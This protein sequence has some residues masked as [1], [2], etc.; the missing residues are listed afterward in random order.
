MHL[1]MK[2]SLFES[3]LGKEVKKPMDL[4]ISMGCK[5]H[6]KEVVDMVKGREAKYARAKKLLEHAQKGYEK[7][8]NKTQRHVEFEVGQHVWL[9]I[10]DFKMRNGLAPC[11]I[12][13]YARFHEIL[14]KLHPNVY[15]L[16]LPSNFV[17]HPT[18]HVS[19]LKLFLQDDQRPNQKQKV[20]L[21]M[22]V[23][24]HMLATKIKS[25]FCVM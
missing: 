8:A 6:F 21:E 20:Q 15:T 16:K 17:A 13:K 22:D 23:I 5:D 1:A 3:T 2:M 25:I 12:A 4:A 14:H 18:F 19:K 11:F 24:K 10:Q 7:H 9:N